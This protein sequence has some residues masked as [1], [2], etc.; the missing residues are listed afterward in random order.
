MSRSV[1]SKRAKTH[2]AARPT[3]QPTAVPPAAAATKESDASPNET[4]PAIV[5]E[6]AKR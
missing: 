5:A 4:V 3:S 6:T 2:I 1:S